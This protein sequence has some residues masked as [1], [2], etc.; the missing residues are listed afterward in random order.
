MTVRN[1]APAEHWAG[2]NVLSV[3][4]RIGR[5][6][7]PEDSEVSYESLPQDEDGDVGR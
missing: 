1:C 6:Q 7:L 5:L 3:R 2:S 4:L